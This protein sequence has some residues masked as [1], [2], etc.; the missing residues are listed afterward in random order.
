MQKIKIIFL[1][2]AASLWHNKSFC[3]ENV[4]IS[5]TLSVKQCV[6]IAIKNNLLVQ[7]SDINKQTNAVNFNQAKDYLLPYIG[8]SG[9]Q[10]ISFGRSLNISTYSYVNQQIATG[11]YGISASLVLFNG[12]QVQ[13]SIR[14]YALAYDASKLDLEQQKQNITLSVLLAYLQVLSSQDL[15]D[16]SRRQ[17]DVDAKQV[18]RLELQNKEGALVLLSN[19]TDLKGQYAS[20]MVSIATAVNTLETAKINL[21]QLLNIPYKKDAQYESIPLDLQAADYLTSSDSIY[22]IALG[23]LPGINSTDLKIKSYQRGLLAA[24]G[25]YYPTLSFNAGIN[26]NYSNAATTSVPGST[27]L[28]DTTS[29]YITY[30]GN[31]YK[32]IQPNQSSTTKNISFGDQ[33]NNN[34]YTS[35][36]L[37]LSVPILNYLRARNNVKL[38]KINLQ[39]AL[40]N[41]SYA[42]LALQQNVEQ[43]YQNMILANSQC[44]SY[45]D[46][47]TAFAES[48][49]TTLI[50]F[51]E[52]VVASDVYLLAKNK[53]DAANINLS[54]AKYNYIFRVKI[55]DYYQGKLSW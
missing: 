10:A 1:F 7:Q 19:L 37:T 34:Q 14:Q 27:T 16:M 21:F 24:R 5:S 55:L 20:D 12:L 38:A 50:R 3:Q 32:V 11:N 39:N 45:Q 4:G 40:N 25:Q 48:F 43:A 44:K 31:N 17:A 22:N 18:E 30:N 26:T 46:A 23:T 49:R 6:D 9:T 33:F 54:I 42:R 15:L 35:L 51:N 29:S 2:F 53:I 41:A 28:Y 13:N 47:V 52:G 36:N 8:A